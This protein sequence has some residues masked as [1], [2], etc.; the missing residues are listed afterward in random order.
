MDEEIDFDS[1]DHEPKE[2][3][4]FKAPKEKMVITIPLNGTYLIGESISGKL[5]KKELKIGDILDVKYQ[6][7]SR[8][9]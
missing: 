5:E 9:E 2:S 6:F 3:W 8:I 7:M 1:H 4:V